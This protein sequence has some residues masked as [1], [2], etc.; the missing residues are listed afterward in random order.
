MHITDRI[1]SSIDSNGIKLLSLDLFDT[2]IFRKVN[3][4]QDI[5]SIS[6][7]LAIQHISLPIEQKEY[8]ELRVHAEKAA[9]EKTQSEDITL[10]E[11]YAEM[12][13]SKEQSNVL[14]ACELAAE[15]QSSFILPELAQL[16]SEIS[17]QGISVCFISDMYLSVTQIRETFFN[18]FPDLTTIPLFVSSQIRLTKSSGKIFP[19][20]KQSCEIEYSDW[21]HV[22]DNKISDFDSPRRLGIQAIHFGI[23]LDNKMIGKAESEFYAVSNSAMAARMLAASDFSDKE[24]GEHRIAH[25]LGAFVWGPLFSNFA[26][27]IIDKTIAANSRVILCLMREGHLLQPLLTAKL[28][29][30]GIENIQVIKF[31]ISRRAAFWPSVD[32]ERQDWFDKLVEIWVQTRGYTVVNFVRDFKIQDPERYEKYYDYDL[33]D[34]QG[35]YLNETTVLRCLTSEARK[36]QGELESYIRQQKKM[37]HQYFHQMV[38]CNFRECVTVDFGCGGTAQGAMESIFV[39]SAKQNLLFYSAGRIYRYLQKTVYSSFIGATNNRWQIRNT[40]GRSPECIEALMLGD[41]GS[42]LSYRQDDNGVVLPVVGRSIPENKAICDNFLAGVLKF[43]E[44]QVKFQ[45]SKISDDD[46]ISILAR[47]IK[48][49]TGAESSLFQS[50]YHQDNFGADTLF[51]I[52][53]DKQ[54]AEVKKLGIVEM[55][56]KFN[57]KRRWGYRRINWPQAVVSTLDKHY[58]FNELGINN[59]N[60]SHA[61][62]L[63]DKINDK[64]WDEFAIYGV[65]MFYETMKPLFEQHNYKI[66]CLID[67]KAE[68][69]DSLQV[70]G[71]KVLTIND[72][73]NSGIPRVVVCSNAFIDEIVDNITVSAR[74]LEIA[75]PFEI[76][77][78]SN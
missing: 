45:L 3:R 38:D 17:A 35:I 32:L 39:Q 27:W 70:N 77:T 40:L 68:F 73:L 14:L 49:P 74:N 46:C 25:E 53:C 69:N 36:K 47:Y 28:K 33:K 34:S 18:D 8:Q 11:I 5:F 60:F 56:S 31:Y 51:P 61:L 64:G 54:I 16:L 65:G 13:F 71:E 67:R 59:D 76:M 22:G 42:T 62:T 58:L 23:L 43:I 15:Q 29:H 24:A 78:V 66:N 37:I 44:Y 20:V 50:I 41:E 2:L 12:P 6:Y 7:S 21:L 30:R 57:Q 48:Q 19:Y 52:V 1:R 75:Y 9:R 10:E 55:L 72:A 26:D 63:I 4:P